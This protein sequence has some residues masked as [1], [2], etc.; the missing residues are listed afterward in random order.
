MSRFHLLSYRQNAT[1]LAHAGVRLWRYADPRHR[2]STSVILLC[3][4]GRYAPSIARLSLHAKEQKWVRDFS[5]P[6]QRDWIMGRWLAHQALFLLNGIKSAQCWIGRNKYGAPQVHGML[7][8]RTRISISHV[9]GWV[10]VVIHRFKEVGL[11]IEYGTELTLA[12][13]RYF[14]STKEIAQLTSTAGFPLNAWIAKEAAYKAWCCGDSEQL[15]NIHLSMVHQGVANKQNF[16]AGRHSSNARLNVS[17]QHFQNLNLHMG[18][19]F[20]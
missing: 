10:G 7:T 6:Q 8:R 19:A 17:Y 13:A 4:Y 16:V 5:K 9:D 20:L 1:T 12:S 14:L 2:K 15:R 18:L 3:R 11:D